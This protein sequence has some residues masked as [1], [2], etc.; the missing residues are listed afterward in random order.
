MTKNVNSGINFSVL[1]LNIQGLCSSLN[2]SKS[3]IAHS[4]P[5]AIRLCEIFLHKSNDMAFDISG[6]SLE[7]VNRL[8]RKKGGL[9]F[10]IADYLDYT[11][12]SDLCKHLDGIFECIFIEILINDKKTMIGEI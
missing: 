9:A 11:L 1:H 6:Y 12:R 2:K 3:L 4:T 10:Y 8:E 7:F 5:Q